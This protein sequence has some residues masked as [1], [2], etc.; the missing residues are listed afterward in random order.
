MVPLFAAGA[1]VIVYPQTPGYRRFSGR[2]GTVVRRLARSVH[3]FSGPCYAVR[4]GRDPRAVIECQAD[5]MKLA[6]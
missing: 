6:N 2:S 3:G 4:L 1:A 5:E